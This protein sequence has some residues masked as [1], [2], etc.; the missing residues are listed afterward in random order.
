MFPAVLDA[1]LF[2]TVST[3][4]VGMLAERSGLGKIRDAYAVMGFLVA[5]YLLVDLYREALDHVVVWDFAPYVPPIGACLEIDALSVFMVLSFLTLG[6]LVAVFSIRYME[7]DENLTEYYVLFFGMVAGMVGVTFAGDF[8]TFFIFWELMCIT[9]Y[10]LVAFRRRRPLPIEAAFK[11]LIMSAFGSVT[12]ALMMSLL[13]GM[14]GTLNFALLSATL[15]GMTLGPWLYVVLVGLVVGFG[16]KSA[17][18]PMHTWLPDAHPE[19]PSGVSALLSGILIETGLYGLCRVLSLLFGLNIY[20]LLIA[21]FAALTMTIG[22]FMALLQDDVKRLLAYS[23]IAQIGYMLIGF[24]AGTVLG[25][26]GTFAHVFNHSLMKG[27]AFLCTG[28]IVY[29]T[30]E[31]SIRKLE[32]V[33]RAMPITFIALTISVLGL[34]GMPI[35]N[36]FISKFILFTSTFQVD[37]AW[38][39]VL[40]V[41]NSAFSVAYYL[42]L[43]K[44]LAT[45]PKEPLRIKEAPASMA[46]VLVVMTFLII[47]FGIWPQ[48]ILELAE[49][50]SVSLI[51]LE[52]YVRPIVR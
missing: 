24:A 15:H 32:G 51:S 2:F 28:A 9:S 50:A 47:F 39:G 21:V 4:V 44:S 46:F 17:I 36:G 16:I 43:I 23:S 52:E 49:R 19:A 8:L 22:N 35:T 13:Y 12:L 30:E 6:T 20:G 5:G 37:M 27:L 40:G 31:R 14:T 18:V 11:Y 42:R 45:V 48:P 3:F 34:A 41:L 29:R 38:L 1:L 25:I 26:T 10:V 7:Q 33:G